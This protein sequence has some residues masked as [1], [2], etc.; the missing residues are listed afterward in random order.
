MINSIIVL[1]VN[2]FWNSDP[3]G[4]AISIWDP[5][6]DGRRNFLFIDTTSASEGLE[7]GKAISI[8]SGILTIP[9]LNN[10]E[11]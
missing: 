7:L 3:H 4:A 1:Q 11:M 6:I 9:I 2:I 5:V 8:V 10:C